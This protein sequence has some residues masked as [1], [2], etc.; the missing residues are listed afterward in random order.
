MQSI[1]IN[2][3]FNNVHT[4]KLEIYSVFGVEVDSP[5]TKYII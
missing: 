3:K 4:R 1:T 2:T 5:A